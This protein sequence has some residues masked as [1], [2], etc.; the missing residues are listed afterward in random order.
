MNDSSGDLKDYANIPQRNLRVRYRLGDAEFEAE[1]EV[2]DVNQHAVNFLSLVVRGNTVLSGE[3]SPKQ[4]PLFDSAGA[5]T[6][7][8]IDKPSASNSRNDQLHSNGKVVDLL[9]YYLK[10]E[11]DTNTHEQK[12]GQRDQLL[13]ITDYSHKYESKTWVM[14]SDYQTAYQIL[15]RKPVKPPANLTAR[16]SELDEQGYLVR[17]E[18]GGYA[19][20]IK[21][22]RYVDNLREV[23]TNVQ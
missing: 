21:G 6:V 7:T 16:L 14:R 23:R 17:G 1:G 3:V 11:V 4:L 10:F 5:P 12:I 19:L 15:R 8:V 20:T 13:I 18:Q 9:T 2:G 22:Q